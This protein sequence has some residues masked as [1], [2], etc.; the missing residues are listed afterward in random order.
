MR[1]PRLILLSEETTS[2]PLLYIRLL[3]YNKRACCLAQLS[4]LHVAPSQVPVPR[5]LAGALIGLTGMS[6]ICVNNSHGYRFPC[7]R[8][9]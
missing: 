2:D 3:K 5:C 7:L 4:S 8:N 9:K 6:P 1:E